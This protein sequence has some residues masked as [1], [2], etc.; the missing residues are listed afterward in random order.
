MSL[1]SIQKAYLEMLSE[2]FTYLSEDMLMEDRI[3]WLKQNTAS[4]NTNHDQFALHKDPHSI[5][6]F[7]ASN[8]DPNPKKLNTQHLLRMYNAGAFRQ[9][10]AGRVREAIFNFDKYKSKLPEH[11]KDLTKYKSISDIENAVAPHIGTGATKA[12]ER[13]LTKS[14][15]HMPGK[16]ELMYDDDKIQVFHLK[17]EA[18]SQKLYGSKTANNPGVYPTEWCTAWTAPRACMFNQTIKDNSKIFVVHRKSDGAVFQY[19]PSSNQFKDKSDIEISSSDWESLKPS[20]H[21]AWAKNSELLD[22]R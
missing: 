16:H 12:E 20:L 4:V 13:E 22:I 2:Q 19:H 14:R 17:D 15:L 1:I 9:E 6:D 3:D 5:I 10:D 21:T 11:Q 18:T 8:M 7:I